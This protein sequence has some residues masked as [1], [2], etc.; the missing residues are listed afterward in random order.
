M[1][2]KIVAGN[3]KMNTTRNSAIKLAIEI[4][5]NLGNIEREVILFPPYLYLE[6]VKGE[7]KT[8]KLGAQNCYHKE[9]G[10]F[11]GEISTSQLKDFVTHVLVGHSERRHVFG[12]TDEEI[13]KK[14]KKVLKE[15]LTPVFCVGETEKEKE[16]SKTIEVIRRQVLSVVSNQ[17]YQ[18]AQRMILA[19]EP[20]W[21]I[22]TGKTCDLKTAEEVAQ[23][24]RTTI[25]NN[26]N[27]AI[28]E[29]IEILYGGSVKP[30]NSFDFMGSEHLDGVLVG[31]ASLVSDD[32]IKII[33][34]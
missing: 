5:N 22:G 24:I 26:F 15:G 8:V 30:G 28:A 21:A 2:R 17:D 3:W 10:A 25:D 32:F 33:N 12:E 29:N 19:Y 34:S 13:S 20:V 7:L 23:I 9:E 31:G 6:A 16:E 4:E 1:R 11:T 14:V 18:E 27:D